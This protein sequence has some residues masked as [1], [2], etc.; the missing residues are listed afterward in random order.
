MRQSWILTLGFLVIFPGCKKPSPPKVKDEN[1]EPAEVATDEKPKVVKA[2]KPK[3]HPPEKSVQD[4]IQALAEKDPG[5]R[6]K[7][8][9]ALGKMRGKAKEAIPALLSLLRD[10]RSYVRRSAVE[11][12][13]GIGPDAK[14]AVQRLIDTLSDSSVE[15][16][17]EAVLAL[18]R[19]DPENRQVLAALGKGLR[20]KDAEVCKSA[21]QVLVGIGKPA[22]PTLVEA[23]KGKD[24]NVRLRAIAALGRP[25]RWK[26]RWTSAQS[27]T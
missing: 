8:A 7:A 6:I 27:S 16:R 23:L 5:V 12:L 1:P 18:G 20:D 10:D 3:P 9:E 24:N 15:V 21:S 26:S 13:G 19:I 14:D 22:V 2:A 25:S 11:A 4:W 17:R